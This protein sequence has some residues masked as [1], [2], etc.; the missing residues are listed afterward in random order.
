M[1]SVPEGARGDFGD[2]GKLSGVSTSS[3]S[4]WELIGPISELVL[5]VRRSF[6]AVWAFQTQPFVWEMGLAPEK[7]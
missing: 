4:S 5:M 7:V 2:G 1:P 6:L 3:R